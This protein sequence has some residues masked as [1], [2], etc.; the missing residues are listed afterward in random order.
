MYG[1]GSMKRSLLAALCLFIALMGLSVH[2]NRAVAD[3]HSDAATT[4][5][6]LLPEGN[7]QLSQLLRL[8][9]VFGNQVE[10][11]CD[12]LHVGDLRCLSA[13]GTLAT[14][15]RFN[16]PAIVVLV[17]DGHRQQLL[18]SQLSKTHATIVG[19][20]DARRI[21]RQRLADMWTGRFKMIWRADAGAVLMYPG[22]RGEAV[23]WLRRRLAKV[24]EQSDDAD[25]AVVS[26]YFGRGLESRVRHFQ[27]MHEL[28][29]DGLVGPRTQIVLNGLAAESGVPTLVAQPE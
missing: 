14:L 24:D 26:R 1:F 27:L 3:T 18:L 19:A 9:G 25:Q 4:S 7:A 10:A 28:E 8:W 16:R 12:S 5:N 13:R 15:M 23:S 6:T 20:E 22:M 21:T 17:H 2:D 11:S 29:P